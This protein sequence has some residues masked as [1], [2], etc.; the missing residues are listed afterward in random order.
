MTKREI[1]SSYKAAKNQ[2]SQIGIIA[3]LSL[4][5][6]AE[7]MQI[8][9]EAGCEMIFGRGGM[10]LSLHVDEMVA[11]CNEGKTQNEIAEYFG[12]KQP[13]ISKLLKTEQKPK[14][15]DMGS[16]VADLEKQN[17][18]LIDAKSEME[19]SIEKC[20]EYICELKNANE[21]LG[22]ENCR[23]KTENDELKSKYGE[24]SNNYQSLCIKCN[25][26]STAVD[27]LVDKISILKQIV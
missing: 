22:K 5:K 27:V 2:K 11:M 13:V 17:A 4:K 25:Q 24:I 21:T 7:I 23:L 16:T 26:L 12:T 18:E 19:K 20:K 1:I 14:E 15:N 6:K 8:L 3:E 10:D 9:K